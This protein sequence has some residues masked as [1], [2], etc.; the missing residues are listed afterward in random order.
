MYAIKRLLAIF[1]FLL[2][3]TAAYATD[4]CLSKGYGPDPPRNCVVT[5]QAGGTSVNFQWDTTN[6][7]DSMVLIGHAPNGLGDFQRWVCET[8]TGNPTGSCATS[9]LVTHHSVTASYLQPLTSYVWSFASCS[10]GP[11]CADPSANISTSPWDA[12]GYAIITTLGVSNPSN[13]I[14]WFVMFQGAK[15]VYRGSSI[16]VGINSLLRDGT[17]TFGADFNYVVAVTV[18]GQDC[19]NPGTLLGSECGTGGSDTHIKFLLS[20]DGVEP[21]NPSTNNYAVKLGA[22]LPYV[23]HYVAT[24]NWF[25]EPGMV[26]RL[27]TDSS[28]TLGAHVLSMT[29]QDAS[30]SGVSRGAPVTAT[31]TFN[32]LAA[33][34][35][36]PVPPTSFPAIPGFGLWKSRIATVGTAEVA[37]WTTAFGNG[38]FCGTYSATET[39]NDPCSVWNFDG[40]QVYKSLGD[41]AASVS[42]TWANGH[43]YSVG[44]QILDSNGCVEVVQE[45]HS[46][47]SGG[48]APTWP[49]CTVANAGHITND[50]STLRWANGENKAYWNAASEL[51]GMPYMDWAN[52]VGGYSFAQEWAIFPWGAAMDFYRQADAYSGICSS[53]GTNCVGLAAGAINYL[54]GVLQPGQFNINPA[55]YQY[56]PGDT[57]RALP[58]GLE[59][60]LAKCEITNNVGSC[61][62]S[63]EVKRRED[64]LFN[65][66]D[67]LVTYSPKDGVVTA[68]AC[69]M[70]TPMFDLGYIGTALIYDYDLRVHFGLTPDARVPVELKRLYD[71]EY[72]F[73]NRIGTDYTF[74][75][76]PW[77]VGIAHD[78][79]YTAKS[80][81]NAFVAPNVAWLWA[82]NGDGSTFPIS[83]ASILTFAD[84]LWLHAMDQV[85][86]NGKSFNMVNQWAK[87]YTDLRTG[88]YAATGHPALPAQNAFEGS[89]PDVLGPFN[90]VTDQIAP[91]ASSITSSS[92]LITWRT[93][94][95]CVSSRVETGVTA[96]N[97]S[98]PS[99]TCGASSFVG[100]ST[101]MWRNQCMVSTLSPSI[102]YYFSPGCTDTAGNLADSQFSAAFPTT[103]SFTTAAGTAP[104]TITSGPCPAGVVGVPYT[105]SLTA[106]GGTTP[107]T[108]NFSV[109]GLTGCTGLSL[110][111]VSNVGV[112]S[113]TPS[114]A[115][116]CSFT[117]EVTDAVVATATQPN[118][119]IIGVLTPQAPVLN[120]VVVNGRK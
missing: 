56:V 69:C 100:G 32:V 5:P 48:T 18:D 36:T 47:M 95:K 57:V 35:F 49:A 22:V 1:A 28:A 75:Y 59:A 112:I 52:I 84:Q 3:A 53:G 7:A 106:G 68:Y 33:A 81:S 86:W 78:P 61:M 41:Q 70:S 77:E 87:Y 114:A 29:F 93:F 58:F 72:P 96:S 94:E 38:R 88:T 24:A 101:N 8:S 97:P 54:G 92:A 55:N 50:G 21:N 25:Q 37:Q 34:A 27:V 65:T 64:L 13:P 66:I 109:G 111:T 91:A 116:S 6:P 46:G 14:S 10:T 120:N 20:S 74:P 9:Q 51:I 90:A 44:D 45:A 11:G 12:D 17:F 43:A 80:N 42:A 119:I 82:M 107:Y 19:Q 89:Y 71:W 79:I 63:P 103:F 39:A 98:G 117:E 16:N 102:H 110:A 83:G 99:A 15:N 67:A 26:A 31:W 60:M 115:G 76:Q 108:W 30:G 104:L 23:N 2:L 113:G 62:D 40:S 118:S 105:C 73:F 85:P 4:P